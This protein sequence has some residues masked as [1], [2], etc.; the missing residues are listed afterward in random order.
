MKRYNSLAEGM[1]HIDIFGDFFDLGKFLLPRIL[2]HEINFKDDVVSILG[3]NDWGVSFLIRVLGFEINTDRA[4]QVLSGLNLA[5]LY[6]FVFIF[7]F[8]FLGLALGM[9]SHD[10]RNRCFESLV[11]FVLVFYG[12]KAKLVFIGEDWIDFADF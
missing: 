2:G 4:G 11:H 6:F 8:I 10:G 12:L 1:F 5:F 9:L 3:P 7:I